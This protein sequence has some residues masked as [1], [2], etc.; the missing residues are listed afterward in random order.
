MCVSK[1]FPTMQSDLTCLNILLFLVSDWIKIKAFRWLSSTINTPTQQAPA[2]SHDMIKRYRR[3]T[4][5]MF[6]DCIVNTGR[7]IVLRL[8]TIKLCESVPASVAVEIRKEYFKLISE[9]SLNR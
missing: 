5:Y 1:R 6:E 4:H 7:L 9:L 3:I 2:H 8:Y